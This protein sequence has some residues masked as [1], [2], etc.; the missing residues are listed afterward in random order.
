MLHN[1]AN[2][3]HLHNVLNAT[4]CKLLVA[5]IQVSTDKQTLLKQLQ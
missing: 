4:F 2:F 5:F 3:L 1:I